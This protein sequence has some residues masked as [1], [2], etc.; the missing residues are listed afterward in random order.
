MSRNDRDR[1]PPPTKTTQPRPD[2]MKD[3][4]LL[5]RMPPAR[6]PILPDRRRRDD[7]GA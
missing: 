6:M 2:W 1:P 7:P 3:P 4:A 5:P